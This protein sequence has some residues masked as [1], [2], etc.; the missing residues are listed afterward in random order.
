MLFVCLF[1][2][3]SSVVLARDGHYDR[4]GGGHEHGRELHHDGGRHHYRDSHHH[5]DNR[6]EWHGGGW[7]DYDHEWRDHYRGHDYYGSPRYYSHSYPIVW[8]GRVP[9]ISDIF[10]WLES[11]DSNDA[12][13][14]IAAMSIHADAVKN[15]KPGRVDVNSS[16]GRFGTEW[17]GDNGGEEFLPEERE[18]LSRI[19][20]SGNAAERASTAG[21]EDSRKECQSAIRYGKEEHPVLTRERW[22]QLVRE[23]Q[24]RHSPS[25]LRSFRQGWRDA[26]CSGFE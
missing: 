17:Y 8:D 20:S 2:L 11:R 24:K 5:Y 9:I 16:W 19:V 1:L 4:R 14:Q 13:K 12:A 15:P 6:R 18:E 10:G 3:T 21:Y 26:G 22:S 23:H 25:Y 7:H